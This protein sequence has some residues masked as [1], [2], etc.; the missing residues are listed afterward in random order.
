VTNSTTKEYV[1]F[2][3]IKQ[4]GTSLKYLI[5]TSTIQSTESV[6]STPSTHAVQAIKVKV[7]KTD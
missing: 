4:P 5:L 2:N 7:T 6:K 1:Y 3:A